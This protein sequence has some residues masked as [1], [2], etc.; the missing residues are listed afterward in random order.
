MREG[1]VDGGVE[2]RLSI[3][4]LDSSPVVAG[5]I[6]ISTGP[7][8]GDDDLLYLAEFTGSDEFFITILM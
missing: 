4:V 3:A 8:S 2:N 7:D 1:V 6:D 5:I